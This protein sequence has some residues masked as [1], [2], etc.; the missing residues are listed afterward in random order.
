MVFLFNYCSL[1]TE[2]HRCWLCKGFVMLALNDMV[3]RCK[4]QTKQEINM[5]QE[6]S[7]IQICWVDGVCVCDCL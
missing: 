6:W 4:G 5:T 1:S 7:A 3:S 2:A